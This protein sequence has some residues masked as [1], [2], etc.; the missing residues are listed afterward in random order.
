MFTG[1][2]SVQIW[3]YGLLSSF[4][5]VRVAGTMVFV[6]LID[7]IK[8]NIWSWSICDKPGEHLQNS[9]NFIYPFLT[10]D[11]LKKICIRETKKVLK[12][13]QV[14]TT[15]HFE[16]ICDSSTKLRERKIVLLSL[17]EIKQIK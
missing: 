13:S 4:T 8:D 14:S 6:E 7:T 15:I 2:L 1:K 17:L 9:Q 16:A 5:R 3:W 11:K 12:M 10:F